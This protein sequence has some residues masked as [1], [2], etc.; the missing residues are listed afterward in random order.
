MTLFR[1]ILAA[2]LVAGATGSISHAQEASRVTIVFD[3]S[4]SMWGQID[5]RT[6]LEI[7]REALLDTLDGVSPNTEIGL[8]AYGHR[9]KGQCTDIETLVPV[10]EASRT[11]PAIASAVLGLKPKGKTPLSDA[12]RR[13][14]EE[15][16]YTEEAAT[17]V[18]I[19]DGIETCEADPC[20][21]ATELE[22]AGIGFT[23]HVVGFGLTED[24]GRQVQCLAENTG[25]RFILA[26]DGDALADALT[27]TVAAAP[28]P[29]V[30]P[31]PEPEA[32]A[33]P[34]RV[35]MRVFDGRDAEGV[36]TTLSLARGNRR[37]GFSGARLIGPDGEPID[38]ARVEFTNH[39][40]AMRIPADLVPGAD[41]VATIH[42]TLDEGPHVLELSFRDGPAA[43]LPFE[44]TA[45]MVP[46]VDLE[47]ALASV[48]PKLVHAPGGK[49]WG[50]GGSGNN[51][52]HYLRWFP[53]VNGT[54]ADE[55]VLD[56]DGALLP[57]EYEVRAK[58]G[59]ALATQRV[60]LEPGDRF[61]GEIVFDA[62]LVTVHI[63]TPEG[64]VTERIEVRYCDPDLVDGEPAGCRGRAR[65]RAQHV[66]VGEALIVDAYRDRQAAQ[67][68]AQRRITLDPSEAGG[69]IMLVLEAGER[70]AAVPAAAAEVSANPAPEA[71]S[72]VAV[73]FYASSMD[74]EAR[75]DACAE[76]IEVMTEFADGLLTVQR[77]RT[78][79]L[80]LQMALACEAQG[81]VLASCVAAFAD[82]SDVAGPRIEGPNDELGLIRMPSALVMVEG[83]RTRTFFACERSDMPP[84]PSLGERPAVI[85][86]D[87]PLTASGLAAAGRAR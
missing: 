30:E 12:V 26:D 1:T 69:N 16:R 42:A 63:R 35:Y 33:V 70:V 36:P 53:V 8:I 44:V 9:V 18:L 67:T 2:S 66:N 75:E 71:D 40:P 81:P 55:P 19:T 3:G 62:A 37:H 78:R 85:G 38:E 57:G 79:S 65:K 50:Y 25:G 52:L 20:A 72:A 87:G 56:G 58:L 14:A 24:E 47:Y 82:G 54:V 34:E 68:R 5:G 45:G 64:L 27:E 76:P 17:V 28:P 77:S 43:R 7:A 13:A 48:R 21:L 49:D 29:E 39:P 61:T 11:I 74:G 73:A 6:K 41:D 51:Y 80:E 22:D 31:E 84:F 4:G 59:Q 46:V 60:V 83:D 86:P 15:M 10:G 32:R 23:T